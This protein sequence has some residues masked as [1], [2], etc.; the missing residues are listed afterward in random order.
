MSALRHRAI[1]RND[2]M[3]AIFTI[4]RFTTP[5]GSEPTINVATNNQAIYLPKKQIN[6]N[7]YIYVSARFTRLPSSK[8]NTYPKKAYEHTNWKQEEISYKKTTQP[9]NC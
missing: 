6:N 7:T 9:D 8:L 1:M 3:Y 2:D 4:H 5:S